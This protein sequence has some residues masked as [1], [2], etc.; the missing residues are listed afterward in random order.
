[1]SRFVGRIG[2]ASYDRLRV[3]HQLDIAVESGHMLVILGSN[4]AGKTTALRALAGTVATSGRHLALDGEDLSGCAPWQ[5]PAHGVVLVP[6]GARCFPNLSVEDNLLGA[7]GASAGRR[8]QAPYGQLR[9]MVC[10]YFPILRDRSRQIA[11]TMSGG[12]RQ[13]L[14]I[15]RALM[16]E[17][18]ALI[19]DEPSAGLAPI[20]VEELFV[21]L[22]KIKR[23]T[24]CAIVMAEQNVGYA[25]HIA[26]HCVVLEEGR[27]ALS[28]PMAEVVN[29][30]KLRSAY[31]GI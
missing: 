9:D 22:A 7:H 23:E 27:T 18:S 6:D 14:A 15:G 30:Q 29:H 11:G 5:L 16:A 12:Q 19:L 3:L 2:G 10:G 17:P 28:G 26:D 13:M 21:T 25:T 20:V 8:R 24:G 31:L 1:M 4:G